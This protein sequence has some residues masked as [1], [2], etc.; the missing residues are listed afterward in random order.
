MFWS[1]AEKYYKSV[2]FHRKFTKR[3]SMTILVYL[4]ILS[5]TNKLG[6]LGI[7]EFYSEPVKHIKWSFTA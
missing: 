3:K 1:N 7:T 2:Y 4:T 6:A 5:T